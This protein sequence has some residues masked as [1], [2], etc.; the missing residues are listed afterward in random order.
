MS[1]LEQETIRDPVWGPMSHPALE[2]IEQGSPPW[3][4]HIYLAFWDPLNQVYGFFHW[5]TS[6]N[7]PTHKSQ[8]VAVLKGRTITV[9][10]PLPAAADH[11][12]APSLDFDLR[13]TIRVTHALISGELLAS[14]RFS[15]IDYTPGETI[16]P[17]VPGKP[18][19]HFQ[20]GLHLRGE[21]LLDGV[22]CPIDAMG[23]RTRTWGFRDDSMQ[24]IEYFSLFA[25]FEDFDLSVMKFR[26]P[27]GRQLVDGGLI[28]STRSARATGLKIRRDR[29]GSPLR[30]IV[31]MAQ[32]PA[33]E[34][35]RLQREADFWCPIGLP[36]RD[37]PTFCAHDEVTK[38]LTVDRREGHGLSEQ[39][40]IRFVA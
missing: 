12:K 6:P 2:T 38:W 8:L 5:N 26:W 22:V 7:H 30:L 28:G 34:L 15:P 32:G 24:F 27:D 40:I 29:A 33:I 39:G 21:L 20:Q 16:P 35:N 31:E 14:P 4:D 19:H 10:E 36:E 9:I 23:F 3:K 13:G 37:G 1:A 17:L 25:C 11:F 18:L